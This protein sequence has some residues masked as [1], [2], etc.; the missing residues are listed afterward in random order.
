MARSFEGSGLGLAI[1]RRLVETMG[2]VIEVESEQDV[3][4]TFTV[5]LPRNVPQDEE[6]GEDA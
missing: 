5:R 2:G 1:S 4:S 3:G 6:D